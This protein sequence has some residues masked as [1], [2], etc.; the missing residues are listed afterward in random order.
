M[1]SLRS[2]HG[3]VQQIV[4]A[5]Q[6][7]AERRRGG[8]HLGRTNRDN[9]SVAALLPFSGQQSRSSAH[10]KSGADDEKEVKAKPDPPTAQLL[11]NTGSSVAGA[12]VDSS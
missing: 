3:H 12:P 9:R 4:T 6:R 7:S 1:C 2:I 8:G 5:K 10:A 11:R